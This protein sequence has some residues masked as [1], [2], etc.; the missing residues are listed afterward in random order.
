MAVHHFLENT[1]LHHNASVVKDWDTV[2]TSVMT[3]G[4][5]NA[6]MSLQVY[7]WYCISMFIKGLNKEWFRY[8]KVAA[9]LL[10]LSC[11]MRTLDNCLCENKGVD[12]L[13]SSCKADQRFL[14]TSHIE[15]FLFYLYP[16]FQASFL[17][18]QL[19]RPVC[20]R[21]GRKSRRQVFLCRD[22]CKSCSILFCR[23]KQ[24]SYCCSKT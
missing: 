22:S 15:Q 14:F 13:R 23:D 9:A 12:Q 24:F 8:S 5:H 4:I 11:I 20:V 21:P 18:L 16:K 17:L 19:H 6:N 10:H 1:G 3:F 2:S 7:R